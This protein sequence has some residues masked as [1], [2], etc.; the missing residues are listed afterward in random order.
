MSDEPTLAD[1]IGAVTDAADRELALLEQY[2]RPGWI[3]LEYADVPAMEWRVRCLLA[4]KAELIAILGPVG[5]RER[6]A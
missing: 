5:K 6:A 2:R 3:G 4:A 1:M